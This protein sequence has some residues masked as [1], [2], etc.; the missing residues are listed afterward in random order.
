MKPFNLWNSPIRKSDIRKSFGDYDK[1]GVINM[2]DCS[3]RNKRK[4]GPEHNWS[5]MMMFKIRDE[6][7]SVEDSIMAKKFKQ[8]GQE[9]EERMIAK[10]YKEVEL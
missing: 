9:K 10:K 5:R 4:Q 6:S 1:D 7:D 8:F 3:P 2:F